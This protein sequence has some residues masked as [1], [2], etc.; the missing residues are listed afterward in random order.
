[1]T[2]TPQT[3]TG[4]T[5]AEALC[6]QADIT[7]DVFLERRLRKAAVGSFM[8]L[9]SHDKLATKLLFSDG[10]GLVIVENRHEAHPGTVPFIADSVGGWCSDLPRRQSP[11]R[12]VRSWLDF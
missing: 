2:D 7:G 10:S 12:E 11:S 6:S 4:E 8:E 5:I 3:S 1:M 9:R